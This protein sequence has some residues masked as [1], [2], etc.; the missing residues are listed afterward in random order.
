[1]QS[2]NTDNVFLDLT[3]LPSSLI[4]ARFPSIYQFC[5][6]YGLDI[7]RQPIPVAPAAHYM[8]GGIRTDLWGE[9]NIGGLYACG[10]AACTGVHGAN[11]LASNSLLEGLVFGYRIVERTVRPHPRPVL[12]SEIYRLPARRPGEGAPPQSIAA[13]QALMWDEVGMTRSRQSLLW[14]LD[15]L[16]AWP[17]TTAVNDRPQQ[18]LCNLTLLGRLMAEAALIRE[19]SRGAHFRSDYP[20][21]AEKWRRRITFRNR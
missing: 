7:T 21:P 11:R 12:Q 4:T 19:E 17:S 14:A 10:E 2:H 20:Q 8:I 9:T 1:M 13:L 16:A 6:G 5:Q 15:T 18:E 3:H